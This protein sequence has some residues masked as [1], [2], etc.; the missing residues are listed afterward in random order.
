MIVCQGGGTADTLGLGPSASN[1][2]QVQILS[3]APNKEASR[4]NKKHQKLNLL[5]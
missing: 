3:L 2:V 1:G 4:K 5:L